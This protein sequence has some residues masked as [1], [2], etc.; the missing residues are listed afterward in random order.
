MITLFRQKATKKPPQKGRKIVFFTNY[1][2]GKIHNKNHHR[3]QAVS[4]VLQSKVRC[5]KITLEFTATFNNECV[6]EKKIYS[7]L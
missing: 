2:F 4:F 6:Y 1:F 7:I 5:G 3:K